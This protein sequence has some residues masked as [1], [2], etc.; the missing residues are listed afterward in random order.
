MKTITFSLVLLIASLTFA[1]CNYSEHKAENEKKTN[2]S[3]NKPEREQTPGVNSGQF[4]PPDKNS[5]GI[6]SGKIIPADKLSDFFPM[7][8]KG[9]EKIPGNQ[10]TQNWN[11]KVY[12]S[13]S[14]EFIY[15]SGGFIVLV[16]DFGSWKNI[17]DSELIDFED[18]IIESRKYTEK[19]KTEYGHGYL[20]WDESK[21]TGVLSIL[22]EDRFIV[23]IDATNLPKNNMSLTDYLNMIKIKKMIDFARSFN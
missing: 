21:R 5:L 2:E 7:E 18:R 16:L 15:P 23:K 14:V 9:A 20:Q 4:A 17:P 3:Q 10:G 19:I 12:S 8:I 6:K 22:V 13:A 11:N 1:G